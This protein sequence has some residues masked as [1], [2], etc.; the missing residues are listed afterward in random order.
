MP[1]WFVARR[2]LTSVFLLVS[3]SV[4]FIATEKNLRW[5]GS[6]IEFPLGR[7]LSL[8]SQSRRRRRQGPTQRV[9]FVKW[10]TSARCGTE[11]T[12]S[13]DLH[14]KLL[15]KATDL[16]NTTTDEDKTVL[17]GSDERSSHPS[18][19]VRGLSQRSER[20][21]TVSLEHQ[22]KTRETANCTRTRTRRIRH[23]LRHAATDFFADPKLQ[24]PSRCLYPHIYRNDACH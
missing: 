15:N 22:K 6:E 4:P 8:N 1:K 21:R 14:T 23:L 18:T 16:H 5:F 3:K 13:R 2:N 24:L 19:R 11:T 9:V 12:K 17:E 7:I 10:V 20:A